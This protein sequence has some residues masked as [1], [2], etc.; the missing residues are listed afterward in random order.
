MDQ[1]PVQMQAH[2]PER[3]QRGGVNLACG[4]TTCCCCCCCL[5]S[6]GGLVG[7][8][9]APVLGTAQPKPWRQRL[10]QHYYDDED[11]P[12]RAQPGVS[13]AG[14]YWLLLLAVTPGAAGVVFL[15]VRDVLVTGILL[16]LGL[17]LLQIGASVLSFI[18]LALW[19]RPDQTLQMSQVGKITL[20]SVVGTVLGLVV[21]VGLGVLALFLFGR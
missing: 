20:G 5:H 8:A 12:Q 6:V 13:G 11:E 2:P 21:M 7:A 14:L 1:P 16:A 17:P 18:G 15:L 4:A 10:V 3:R 9:V 19:P